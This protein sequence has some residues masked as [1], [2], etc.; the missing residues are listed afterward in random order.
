MGNFFDEDE[1]MDQEFNLQE[2]QEEHKHFVAH[3]NK[4][5]HDE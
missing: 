3:Q 4:G 2:D 1:E 5:S